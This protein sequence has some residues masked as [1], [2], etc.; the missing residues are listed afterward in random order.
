M[1][2]N[3]IMDRIDPMKKNPIDNIQI[4]EHIIA[5]LSRYRLYDEIDPI[6]AIN[7]KIKNIDEKIKLLLLKFILIF[8]KN[9][10]VLSKKRFGII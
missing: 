8:D 9:L 7:E 4:N 1:I 3:E 5:I 2:I 10:N 6:N